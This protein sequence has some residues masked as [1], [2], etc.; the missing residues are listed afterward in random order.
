MASFYAMQIKLG[1]ITID[2]VPAVWKEAVETLM[3]REN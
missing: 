2:Q 3:S 1:N